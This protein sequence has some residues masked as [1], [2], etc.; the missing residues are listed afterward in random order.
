MYY[1]WKKNH[2]CFDRPCTARGKATIKPVGP[3]FDGPDPRT[4]WKRINW[5]MGRMGRIMRDENGSS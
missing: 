3:G 5:V 1:I 4:R 2:I